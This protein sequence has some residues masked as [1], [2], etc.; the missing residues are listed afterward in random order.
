MRELFLS[1]MKSFE[2]PAAVTAY[3]YFSLR[4]IL[5]LDYLPWMV[6]ASPV[7]YII[8]PYIWRFNVAF[9]SVSGSV[10]MPE[11]TLCCYLARWNTSVPLKS[12]ARR[13]NLFGA[14]F[15]CRALT[16]TILPGMVACGVEV[17]YSRLGEISA[18]IKVLNCIIR[19]ECNC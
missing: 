16:H 4:L 7:A 17:D 5:I 3:Y 12:S 14:V 2:L 1:R 19:L 6:T 10:L 18:Y 8:F 11:G 15:A 9:T 13:G